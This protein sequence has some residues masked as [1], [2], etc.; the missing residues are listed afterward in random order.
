MR[1]HRPYDREL[2][3]WVDRMAT[4]IQEATHSRID[5]DETILRAELLERSI[6]DGTANPETI[7]LDD[8]LKN[9][10]YALAYRVLPGPGR[11][12]GEIERRAK[13]VQGFIQ[14][15][16]WEGE[17]NGKESLL[18]A[19]AT[20][21]LRTVSEPIAESHETAFG[22]EEPPAG[23]GRST[24]ETELLLTLDRALPLVRVLLAE[25]WRFTDPEIRLLE[26]ELEAWFSRFWKRS[27]MPPRN[28]KALVVSAAIQFARQHRQLATE[29]A[30]DLSADARLERLLRLVLK[31][32]TPRVR[33]SR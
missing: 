8:D 16:S 24:L 14:G 33:R 26:R 13:S 28:P 1:S 32:D 19:C 6:H 2:E 21:H 15:L 23:A 7:N 29:A 10:L 30:P 17:F 27:A 5:E 22:P 12:P 20:A 11:L 31:E 18:R 3:N 25:V 9:I 4:L